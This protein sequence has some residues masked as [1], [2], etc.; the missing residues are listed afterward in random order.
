M[1]QMA[2]NLPAMQETWVQSLDWEDSVEKEIAAYSSILA[3]NIPWTEGPF[4]LYSPWGH[5][6]SDTTE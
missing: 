3:W 5:K 6:E 1:A 2:K 4:R